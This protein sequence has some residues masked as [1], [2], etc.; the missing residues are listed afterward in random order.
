MQRYLIWVISAAVAIPVYFLTTFAG[1]SE[2]PVLVLT[3]IGSM[4]GAVLGTTIMQR[5]AGPAPETPPG[6]G[7]GKTEA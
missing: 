1:L 5:R 3:F 7:S 6:R 4:A 2:V